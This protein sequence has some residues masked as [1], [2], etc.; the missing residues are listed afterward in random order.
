MTIND[1]YLTYY[2][3]QGEGQEESTKVRFTSYYDNYVIIHTNS[4]YKISS[5]FITNHNNNKMGWIIIINAVL[6]RS[7]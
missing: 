7:L 4:V 6:I 2:G 1:R 3:A 5:Y